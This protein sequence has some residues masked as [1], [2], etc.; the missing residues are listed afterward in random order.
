MRSHLAP[1]LLIAQAVEQ[2]GSD[3]FGEPAWREGL[4]RYLESVATEAQLNDI[5]VEMVRA[6][7]VRT[8]TNRLAIN[9]FR[10]AHPTLAEQPILQP[11]VIVGQPRTG[12]TI[13]YDLLALDPALRAPL[14]WEVDHPC[15]PPEPETYSTDE[16]ID[17]TQAQL[18]LLDA[19]RPGFRKHH[20][21]GAT[22]AQECVRI[23]AGD[24]RSMLYSVQFDVPSYNTWLLHEADMSSAYRWHR[25]YLQHLQHAVKGQWLL[26]SPAH[27]WHLDALAAEYPD[28]VVVQTHRDPL[29]VISSVS[30]LAAQLRSLASDN[31]SVERAAEQYADDIL[32]GL[33]K[34]MKARDEGVFPAS[35]LVDVQ[36]T[37]FVRS[38][39]PFL[40]KLYA[41]LGREL[42][43]DTEQR[44]RDFLVAHPGD[45]GGGR[46]RWAD[47]GLD[48]GELRER[49][50]AYQ[51]RYDVPS[52]PL[53]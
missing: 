28:A 5:G 8:L 3:D 11:I 20:P 30:A 39:F 27:L 49:V 6:D 26:K 37:D 36:L 40:H 29:R 43:P 10:A 9:A 35:Q 38:P 16:R 21:V 22:L 18:D 12:T 42:T 41:Q 51:E 14:T 13:L 33:D 23:T 2:A 32:F 45:G 4:E 48:A 46:Y 19:L 17:Q 15:P 24:F 53:T 47:T 52:E 31:P 25:R 1:D 7:V 50:A 34:A 44:M